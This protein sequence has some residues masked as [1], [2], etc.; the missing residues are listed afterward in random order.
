MH[1]EFTPVLEDVEEVL[2]P[3]SASPSAAPKRRFAKGLVGWV[4]FAFLAVMLFVLKRYKAHQFALPTPPVPPPAPVVDPPQD[5]LA[6]LLPSLLP[7]AFLSVFVVAAIVNQRRDPRPDVDTVHRRGKAFL[8]LNGLVLTGTVFAAFIA[9]LNPTFTVPWHPSRNLQLFVGFLPWIASAALVCF[10]LRGHRAVHTQWNHAP[11]LRAPKA[12][13]ADTTALTISTDLTTCR[14]LWPHFTSFRETPNLFVLT[15]R[16]RELHI[17]PKRAFPDPH[18]LDLFRG[19]LQT[20]IP[21]GTTLPIPSAFP[22][23]MPQ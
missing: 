10:L 12:V 9:V 16:D 4:V 18:A 1:I 14:Y 19:L 5:L 8:K 2:A 23:V 22:V 15:T 17:L 6:T 13:D 11:S 21:T 20:A 7:C 3:A